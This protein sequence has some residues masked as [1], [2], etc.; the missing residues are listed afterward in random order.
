MQSLPSIPSIPST[1]ARL[2]R[3]ALLFALPSIAI[4]LAAPALGSVHVS[5]LR[6]LDWRIP[7]DQNLDAQILFVARLPRTLAGIAV[8]AALAAAGVVFQGLLRNPLATPFTLG[9]SAGSAL[10][11]MLAITFHWSFGALGFP[12]VPLASLAGS[13]FA[14]AIVYALA[15][16]RRRR[17]LSTTVLLL[18]GVTLNAFFSALILFVQYFADFA[19]TFRAVRWLMGDLDVSS[20]QP[21]VAALPLLAI[22]GLLPAVDPDLRDLL[23]MTVGVVDQV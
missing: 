14:V 19:E 16:M 7:F 9:V 2:L 18:A 11:A 23:A 5:L 10:G 8:G 1:R 15:T 20:Y 6:A 13:L 3:V 22:A 4:C 17:A 21:I 12:A